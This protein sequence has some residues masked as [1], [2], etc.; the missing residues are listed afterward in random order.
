VRLAFGYKVD[1]LVSDITMPGRDGYDLIQELRA[2]KFVAPAIAV[3]GCSSAAE[4]SRAMESGFD[5]HLAKPVGAQELL[6]TILKLRERG[7]Q[8][9]VENQ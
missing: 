9:R 5:E 1:L 6:S 7:S 2:R 3:T 8:L 4:I